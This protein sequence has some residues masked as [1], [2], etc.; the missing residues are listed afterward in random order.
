MNNHKKIFFETQ[1]TKI[2]SLPLENENCKNLIVPDLNQ[3]FK[4]I[5]NEFENEE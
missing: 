1:Q 5:K 3:D 2:V 4:A